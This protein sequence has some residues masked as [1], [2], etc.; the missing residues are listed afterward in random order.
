MI[1]DPY[2]DWNI[3]YKSARAFRMDDEINCEIKS[4]KLI[5]NSV[6]FACILVA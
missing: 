3:V 5:H 6:S 2:F 4:L 1:S